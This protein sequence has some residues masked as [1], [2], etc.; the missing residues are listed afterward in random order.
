MNDW[1]DLS[2]SRTEPSLILI[3]DHLYCFDNVNSK[4]KKD[5]LTIER[6]DVTLEHGDWEIIQ[7][8]F[9]FIGKSKIKSKIFRCIKKY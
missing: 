1:G 5:E 4:G 6:T 3:S 9:R 8:F 7:P 2:I